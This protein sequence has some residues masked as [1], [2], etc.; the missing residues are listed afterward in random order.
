MITFC[1]GC[2]PQLSRSLL[3]RHNIQEVLVESEVLGQLGVE[4]TGQELSL[5]SGD[6]GA[7]IQPGQYLHRAVCPLDEWCSD[8]YTLSLIHI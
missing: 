3:S 6:Y 5:A 2:P 1:K 7:I 8:E 4:G